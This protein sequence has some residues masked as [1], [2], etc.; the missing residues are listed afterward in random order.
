NGTQ[1]STALLGLTLAG[2][3]RLVRAADIAA[4]LSV[5]ALRGSSHPF[6]ARIHEA[7]GLAGQQVSAANLWMLMSGS[8]INASHANC[9]RVQ[10]AYSMRCAA[11]VHGAARDAFGFARQIF[12]TEANAATDNPMV[13]VETNEI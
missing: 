11:Q 13:F 8:G 9:G 7:R 6:E 5:D 12:E 1:A 2:I 4:A 3:E 10:D